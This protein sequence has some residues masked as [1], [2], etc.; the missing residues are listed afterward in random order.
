MSEKRTWSFQKKT[1]KNYNPKSRENLR[2]YTAPQAEK[3]T[4]KL[5]RSI[6]E[7]IDIDEDLLE[8]IVPTKKVFSA[9][10]RKRFLKLIK[11]HLI[12]L[13]E[14]DSKITTSDIQALSMVCKNLIME[15]RLLADAQTKA[16][17]DPT[18]IAN[19]MA[20]IDK[21]K[22]AN[23]KLSEGLATNRNMRVDPRSGREFT[24]MDVLYEFDNDR[25]DEYE[26][27][28]LDEYEEK[29]DKVKD[30]VK[31]SVEDLIT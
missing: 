4:K 16:K 18:A 1:K 23:E 6:S 19:V 9:D 2:Q 11:L 31:S 20:S 12:E 3:E 7:E 8:V 17:A 21:L 28:M 25:A 10:E 15:D 24:V 5:L 14:H 13:T 26:N 30:L 27:R 29:E 22:K